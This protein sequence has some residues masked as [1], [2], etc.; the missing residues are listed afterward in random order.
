METSFGKIPQ[1]SALGIRPG[2]ASGKLGVRL[3]DVSAEVT[4]EAHA[5]ATDRRAGGFVVLK[6]AA[7]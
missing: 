5:S 6:L 1:L 7:A 3:G 2:G 4:E